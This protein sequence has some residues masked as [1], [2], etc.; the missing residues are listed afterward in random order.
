[1]LFRDKLSVECY[2]K[3][4][5]MIG[6]VQSSASL[7]L[8]VRGDISSRPRA[9]H[10][11]QLI[12]RSK[13]LLQRCWMSLMRNFQQKTEDGRRHVVFLLIAESIRMAQLKVY[14]SD[15]R[16]KDTYSTTEIIDDEIISSLPQCYD[17][18]LAVN[19]SETLIRIN[20]D[21]SDWDP[22]APNIKVP[23]DMSSYSFW[24]ICD[25][26]QM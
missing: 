10:G 15:I 2:R 3:D 26:I 4:L 11:F 8:I 22:L 12:R 25:R 9:P 13:N 16:E 18:N 17:L 20:I 1:M 19:T 23:P 6:Q 21:I 5:N 14:K 7:D 24:K